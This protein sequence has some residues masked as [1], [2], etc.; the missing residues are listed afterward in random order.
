MKKFIIPI[1]LIFVLVG[2]KSTF[3]KNQEANL[4]LTESALTAEKIKN[5]TLNSGKVYTDFLAP[6]ATTSP[7]DP[8]SIGE[9]YLNPKVEED[10]K[11][12]AGIIFKTS[13]KTGEKLTQPTRLF[14]LYNKGSKKGK[15]VTNKKG[16]FLTEPF[17][18]QIKKVEVDATHVRQRLWIHIDDKE[19][20]GA[21]LP[22]VKERAAIMVNSQATSSGSSIVFQELNRGDSNKETSSTSNTKYD[23]VYVLDVVKIPEDKV[24]TL[25]EGFFRDKRDGSV[26]T[27][28]DNVPFYVVIDIKGREWLMNAQTRAIRPRAIYLNETNPDK[29]TQNVADTKRVGSN[30]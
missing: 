1:L 18:G 13:I 17:L 4:P 26:Y 9:F 25:R 27:L 24:D 30:N 22:Y 12:D 2:C 3:N 16:Q 14:V 29:R 5:S 28:E 20:G 21:T 11:A 19:S 7:T 10:Q 23:Y 15:R 6:G 8:K